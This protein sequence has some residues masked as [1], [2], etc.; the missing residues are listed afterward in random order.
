LVFSFDSWVQ[1]GYNFFGHPLAGGDSTYDPSNFATKI[2]RIGVW[3]ENYDGSGLSYT[4]RVYLVPA[5]MDVLRAPAANDFRTRQWLVRDMALPVPYPI[6][7]NDLENTE[8]IPTRDSLSASF[9][10]I[11]RFSRFRAYHDSGDFSDSE[12]V[13]D[14]RLVCRSVWNTRWML[15]IPGETLLYPP[16]EGLDTFIDGQRLVDSDVRDGNGIKDIKLFFYTYATS[17]N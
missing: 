16:D 3:F 6:G 4:P 15:I 9:T 13:S 10:A 5:G 2:R 7:I 14:S 17:G 1:F 8:W 12:T 11:R